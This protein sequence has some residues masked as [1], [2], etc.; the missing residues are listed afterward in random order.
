MNDRAVLTEVKA[1][2]VPCARIPRAYSSNQEIFYKS[3][4][5]FGF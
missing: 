2:G 5:I 4:P 1:W 3:V